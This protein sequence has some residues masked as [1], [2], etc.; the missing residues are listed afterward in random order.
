M[1]YVLAEGRVAESGTHDELYAMQ[2]AYYE[3]RAR[4]MSLVLEVTRV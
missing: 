1:I 2:G 3:V 4:S